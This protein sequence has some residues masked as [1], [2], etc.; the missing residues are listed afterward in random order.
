MSPTIKNT[1]KKSISKMQHILLDTNVVLDLLLRRKPFI[2][3]ASEIFQLIESKDAKACLC[4]TTVSNIDYLVTKS[5][6][7]K[8]SGIP[9]I[10]TRNGKDFVGCGLHVYSPSEWLAAYPL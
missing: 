5:V 10:I 7:A 2:R 6:S 3:E 8:A 1:S 9:A 4:A